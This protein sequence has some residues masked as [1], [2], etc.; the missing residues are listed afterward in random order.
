MENK[1]SWE[2]VADLSKKLAI[3]IKESGF[4]PDYLVGITVG[5]LIPLGLLAEELDIRNILTVSVSSYEGKERRG[6]EVKYLPDIDLEGKKVLLVDEVSETGQ[7]LQYI[8]GLLKEK[9]QLS[10][11][12]TATLVVN[13]KE[14]KFHP[15]F[16]SLEAREWM[17]FPWEK[18]E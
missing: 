12:R 18:E 10:E 5:G 13:T 15:D 9:Y 1:L 6:L 14:S 3:T 7:T 4:E 8:A 2:E 16:Y 17:V 11:L